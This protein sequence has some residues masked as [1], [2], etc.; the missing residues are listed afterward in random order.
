M[1]RHH[2]AQCAGS[3]IEVPASLDAD[4]LGGRDLDGV[5]VVAVPERLQ[6]AVAEA[7]RHDVLDGFLAEEMVDAI[8]LRLA[9]L[10]QDLRV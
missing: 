6:D 2:V 5:D 8:D 9:D 3:F 7:E 10:R 1:V 4:R